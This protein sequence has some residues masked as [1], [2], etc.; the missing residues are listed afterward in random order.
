LALHEALLADKAVLEKRLAEINRALG[1]SRPVAVS[2][3]VA[4]AKPA[5]KPAKARVQPFPNQMSLKQAVLQVTREKPLTKKEI[6]Q[7]VLKLGYRFATSNPMN[8]LNVVLY[9][10]KKDIKKRDGKFG[11]A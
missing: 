7:E 9:S 8:T 4:P 11:P 10:H 6:L 3:P 1:A 2:G 5:A